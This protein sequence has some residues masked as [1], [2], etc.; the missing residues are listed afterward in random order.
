LSPFG[1]VTRAATARRLRNAGWRAPVPVICCGN[2]TVGGTGKTPLCLDLA[3][4]LQA[5]GIAVHILTRGYRGTAQGVTRVDNARHDASH[6]G[7]EALLLARAAPTWAGANRAETARQAVAA[8]AQALIMDDGLQ[9]ATLQKT[10]ALLVIDGG[11]GFGNNHLLPAGPLREPVAI[12]A[13]RCRAAIMIGNDTT[14]AASILPPALPVLC[15]RLVP[16]PDMLAMNGRDV[17][18]F[19]GIGRPAKFFASLEQAGL[20][21]RQCIRYPDHYAYSEKDLRKL[22]RI[23][24][25]CSAQLVTTTKDYVRL[26]QAAAGSIMPLSVA[27]KWDNEA[28]LEALLDGVMS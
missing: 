12:A 10:C 22:Q 13:A 5:R 26:A 20:N 24:N 8:G 15:A 7:D 25:A 4:R 23:A 3:A 27:I 1:I 2:A 6:V 16:S 28:G 21:L 19:A 17:V 11:A 14:G 9:N 18:A